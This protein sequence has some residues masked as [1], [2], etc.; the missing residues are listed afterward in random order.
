MPACVDSKCRTVTISDRC[1]LK[2]TKNCYGCNGRQQELDG[3]EDSRRYSQKSNENLGADCCEG[4]SGWLPSFSKKK[5]KCA[6]AL[7]PTD[8]CKQDK[9]GKSN[10]PPSNSGGCNSGSS[11]AK[12]SQSQ[13]PRRRSPSPAQNCRPTPNPCQPPRLPVATESRESNDY[14]AATGCCTPGDKNCPRPQACGRNSASCC[15]AKTMVVAAA[16]LV[17]AM[18]YKKLQNNS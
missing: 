11:C 9:C 1:Q 14:C 8:P 6:P 17:G 18:A 4:K 15:V 5:R 12:K 7:T 2:D 16:I 13:C 10:P 3:R